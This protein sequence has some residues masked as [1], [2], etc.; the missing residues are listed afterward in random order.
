MTT[1]LLRPF[2][3]RVRLCRA[4][5]GAWIG[6][7]IGGLG[8]VVI[9]L[10]DALN[11]ILLSSTTLILVVTIAVAAATGFC[12]GLL[13]RVTDQQLADSIDRRAGLMDR[14][15]TSLEEAKTEFGAAQV[16]D[17]ETH[18]RGIQPN[19]LYRL[20]F[21]RIQFATMCTVA[22]PFAAVWVSQSPILKS[23]A[24]VAERTELKEAAKVIEHLP[25]P[26][27][28]PERGKASR[29]EAERLKA[30]VEKFRKELEQ[31]K[32]SKEVAMQ[33]ANEL[34]EK[35]MEYAK[36]KKL[37]LATSTQTAQAALDKMK[38]DALAEQGMQLDPQTMAQLSKLSPEATQL[39]KQELE[40]KASAIREK[41]NEARAKAKAIDDRLK[42]SNLSQTEREELTQAKDRLSQQMQDIKKQLESLQKE[43]DAIRNSKAI[44]ELMQKISQRPEMKELQKMM[45]KLQQQAQ[46]DPQVPNLTKEQIE[47]MRQ[48]LQEMKEEL[49]KLAEELK[50]PEAMKAFMQAMKEALENAQQC[51]NGMCLGLGLGGLFGMGLGFP[52]PGLDNDVMGQDTGKVN[53]LDKPAQGGGK[54]TITQ[55]KG[56]KQEQGREEFIEIRGPATVGKRSGVPYRQVLPAYRRKAEEAIRKNAVPKKHETRV[57][58]YFESLGQ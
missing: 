33:K 35:A 53:H 24:Q 16:E 36:G 50:D 44:Q 47:E 27:E 29:G 12:V 21:G 18:L 3:R 56:R 23:P 19:R 49:E 30:E 34:S 11:L 2:R 14:T 54:T 58:K 51:E 9:A 31:A 39:R 55:L 22:I 37:D 20:R 48:K 25:K 5:Q 26:E 28:R 38:S 15:T 32:M 57:K 43:L 13:R 17:A 4:W 8:A 45:Q 6:A 52:S 1:E 42:Q 41:L 7:L 10:L 46:G 40:V